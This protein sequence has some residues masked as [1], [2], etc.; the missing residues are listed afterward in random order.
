M[1][2]IEIE[3]TGVRAVRV[4][5]QDAL[6]QDLA[7]LVWPLIRPQVER[8]HRTLNREGAALVRKLA[9]QAGERTGA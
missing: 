7:L 2:T 5:G 1:L 8:L 3:P 9:P 6:E 4:S